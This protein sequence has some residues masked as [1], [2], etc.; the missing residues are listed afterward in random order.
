VK[1]PAGFSGV[2]R[3]Q[4]IKP[5][6]QCYL[7]TKTEGK[8]RL[9]TPAWCRQESLQRVSALNKLIGYRISVIAMLLRI[10]DVPIIS[11]VCGRLARV[12]SYKDPGCPGPLLYIMA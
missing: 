9:F 3:L 7:K 5:A 10:P 1:R 8:P 12:L 4:Q 11:P 2:G 6:G